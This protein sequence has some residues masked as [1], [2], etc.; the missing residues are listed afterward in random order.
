MEKGE[1]GYKVRGYQVERENGGKT[2]GKCDSIINEIYL[3]NNVC[4]VKTKYYLLQKHYFLLQILWLLISWLTCYIS[5][6]LR[7]IQCF[8]FHL[9]TLRDFIMLVG[10][11]YGTSEALTETIKCIVQSV[12]AMSLV[13]SECCL[14]FPPPYTSCGIF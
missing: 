11:N 10:G 9:T 3:K 14:C 2:Q 8:C 13:F 12:L 5:I 7:I 6:F 4:L 1:D